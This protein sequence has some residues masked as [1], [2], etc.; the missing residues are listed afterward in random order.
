MNNSINC[1]IIGVNYKNANLDIRGQFSL[2]D[3]QL[4]SLFLEATEKKF[5]ELLIINTCNRTEIF[6]WNNNSDERD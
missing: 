5:K 1:Q 3:L 6:G 4:H 2:S